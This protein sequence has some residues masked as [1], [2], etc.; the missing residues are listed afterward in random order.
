[1]IKLLVETGAD[2]SH[3]TKDGK[4]ALCFAASHN[5]PEV[6]SYLFKNKHSTLSLI[7]NKKVNLIFAFHDHSRRHNVCRQ[8]LP[9]SY[10]IT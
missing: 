8:I 4:V 10:T 7:D 6:L 5:Y 1:M 9:T 3:E 2:P